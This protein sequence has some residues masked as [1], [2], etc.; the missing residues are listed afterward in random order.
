M[1]LSPFAVDV[2]QVI[3][4]RIVFEL[5]VCGRGGRYRGVEFI[6]SQE[7]TIHQIRFS[8]TATGKYSTFH[9]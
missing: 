8:P 3:E 5:F 6:N 2:I 1:E 9:T 7:R 4:K